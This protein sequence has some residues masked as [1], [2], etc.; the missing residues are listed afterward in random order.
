MTWSPRPLAV[1]V[2]AAVLALAAG[3]MPAMA[4]PVASPT[5]TGNDISWPQCGG[6]YPAE[7]AFGIVGVN[8]GL[9]NNL[10][11]CLASEL[12][13]AATSTGYGLP[14]GFQTA[15]LYVNTADPGSVVPTVA[16]W[17]IDN[18]DPNGA[19][20]ALGSVNADPYGPCTGN[21]DA[22]CAWQYGWNRAIK[23]MLWLTQTSTVTAI[24]PKSYWWWLDVETGNTWESGTLGLANNVADLRGMVAAFEN[25]TETVTVQSLGTVVPLGGVTTVGVY[26]TSYQWGQITSSL[27]DGYSALVGLP[28]WIPGART[29]SGAQS[30]CALTGFTAA[31]PTITQWFGRPFDGD[32]ACP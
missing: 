16:D 15:A 2:V 5:S 29:L 1:S 13:W 24:L 7:Q 26:S 25:T 11:T 12:S 18:T 9:A 22:A 20:E 10:N 17:P 23:D 19:S 31:K 4:K 28:D 6:S 14:K 30:N 21:N 3:A 8:H 27:A 32:V